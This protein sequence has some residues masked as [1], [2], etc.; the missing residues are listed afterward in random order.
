MAVSEGPG[1][2]RGPLAD[3]VRSTTFRLIVAYLGSFAASVALI[4]VFIYATTTQLIENEIE[5][6]IEAQVQGLREQYQRDGLPGLIQAIALRSTTSRQSTLYMLMGPG[7]PQPLGNLSEWPPGRIDSEGWLEFGL[8]VT[9]GDQQMV[10]PAI[11]KV[12]TLAGG[13]RLLVAEDRE[14]LLEIRSRLVTLGGI[15]LVLVVALGALGGV[16]LSNTVMRRIGA[17]NAVARDVMA[18]SLGR[19]VPVD[20]QRDEL[21]ELGR[22]VNDMLDSI[23]HLMADLRHA[24]DNIAH[25]LRTPLS[26]VRARLEHALA[27]ETDVERLRATMEYSV[28]EIDRLTA[29]FSALLTIATAESGGVALTPG[30]SISE[31]VHTV[32]DLY[33]PAAEQKRIVLSVTVPEGISV[34]GH[35]E[36]LGEAVANL[37]DNAIKYTPAG[38]TVAV[39]LVAEPRVQLRVADSGPGI[40]QA[41]LGEVTKRFYR[42]ES[43][44]STPGS[45][46]G[47]SLVAAVA[48]LHKADLVLANGA[49]GLTASLTF[50][51]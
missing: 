40:P 16:L 34:T 50:P 24:T 45:G 37:I 2:Q 29:I 30:I 17:I 11:G 6:V 5:A 15:A 22:S 3:L 42:V 35:R 32:L 27:E 48:R 51:P 26:R 46:L 41:E 39:Q 8:T 18:G 12:Y 13:Y 25:D 9:R 28:E 36:L 21:D 23:E 19:R 43:S 10:Q 7:L 44:R 1:R 38:G 47:L 20:G 14:A 31:A 49:R 4:L 33:E